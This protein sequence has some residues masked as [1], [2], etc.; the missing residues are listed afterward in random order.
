ME[1]KKIATAYV[2]VSSKDAQQLVSFDNQKDFF[3]SE[4]FFKDHKDVKYCGRIYFDKGKTGTKLVRDGFHE[5]LRD[6]GL[7]V[8][9]HKKKMKDGKYKIVD[10]VYSVSRREP[11]F[12]IIYTKN[13][14]RFAR[15]VSVNTILEKLVEKGVFVRFVDSGYSTEN[16]DQRDFINMFFTFDQRESRDKSKKVMFGKEQ[17]AKND[18]IFTNG[19]LF[20]YKYLKDKNRLEVIEHEAEIIREIFALYI[21]GVGSRR[22]S[23]I[24]NEKGYRRR[25]GGI[26]IPS[27]ILNKIHN[28]KYAGLNNIMKYCSGTI[29]ENKINWMKPKRKGEY[30]VEETDKIPWIIDMKTWNKSQEILN[31]NQKFDNQKGKVTG[32]NLGRTKYA[33]KLICTICNMP[34]VRKKSSQGKF[35]LCCGTKHRYGKDAC[36]A[37]NLLIEDIE[38]QIEKYTGSF[39]YK[40]INDQKKD[41]LLRILYLS[42]KL[43]DNVN[44]NAV[45]TVAEIEKEIN[46]LT[47]KIEGSYLV[48]FDNPKDSILQNLINK[49]KIKLDDLEMKKQSALHNN[50]NI[51]NDINHLIKEY[52]EAVERVP[53]F[54]EYNLDEIV[55]M[56]D[57][58]YITD[59]KI[60][61]FKLDCFKDLDNIYNKYFAENT[62]ESYKFMDVQAVKVR[63]QEVL[64]DSKILNELM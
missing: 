62:R 54:R 1:R 46:D 8:E 44:E 27:D 42:N 28:E 3:E 40:Y 19:K 39:I 33:S 49:M 14:S 21:N 22:I 30:K 17:S 52:K 32:R 43:L 48:L 56:T 45:K 20:G 47:G 55:D 9:P 16:S 57:K 12:N 2:R 53:S 63:V 11:K 58:F 64:A 59:G 50:Q 13:T 41:M 5:M 18:K 61:D 4:D 37:P 6:A 36:N 38:Q 35:Y 24:L 26:F 51:Y 10:Y 23:N 29:F 7:D 31:K 25:D 60:I 15:T 34:Y